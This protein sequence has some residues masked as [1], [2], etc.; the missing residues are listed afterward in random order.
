MSQRKCQ[1]IQLDKKQFK[2]NQISCFH[3]KMCIEFIKIF[4]KRGKANKIEIRMKVFYN[5]NEFWTIFICL[6]VKNCNQK[7]IEWI[8]PTRNL[9]SSLRSNIKNRL[10][11]R[12]QL[13]CLL[14][15]PLWKHFFFFIYI[16]TFMDLLFFFRFPLIS[17]EKLKLSFHR[18]NLNAF[19]A[20]K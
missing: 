15:L 5:N 3:N 1:L 2:Q 11:D 9:P 14:I 20:T 18:I 17:V 4:K 16:H 8:E 13:Q 6:K 12:R 10:L 19:I 7:P